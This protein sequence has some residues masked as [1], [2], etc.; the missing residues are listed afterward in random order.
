MNIQNNKYNLIKNILK[1]L[2]QNNII[3]I[4]QIKDLNGLIM[5]NLLIMKLEIYN[6]NI[7][8]NNQIK[9]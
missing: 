1:L 3:Q 9:H 7:K 6:K 4:I 5:N 2:N 8:L